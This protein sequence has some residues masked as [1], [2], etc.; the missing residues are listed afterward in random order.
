VQQSVLRFDSDGVAFDDVECARNGDVGFGA[1]PMTQPPQS[2]A[3]HGFDSVDA[4][5]RSLGLI[6]LRFDGVHQPPVDVAGS[7]AKHEQN[8]DRDRDQ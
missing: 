2:Q 4:T 8:G 3:V 1:E 7:A 5:E 6:D